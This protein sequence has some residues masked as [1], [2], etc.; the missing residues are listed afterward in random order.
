MPYTIPFSQLKK[1]NIPV[2]GGKGANLGEMISAGFP[3]PAGYIVTT[4]AYDAFIE[5]NGLRIPIWELALNVKDDEPQA[6]EL[7]SERIKLEWVYDQR[8]YIRGAIKLVRQNILIGGTLAIIVLLIFL[9][10]I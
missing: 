10:I 6:T 8:P 3:V 1:N 2:A 4:A 7:A 9:R 5:A